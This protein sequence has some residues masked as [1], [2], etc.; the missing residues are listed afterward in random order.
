MK[1][2]PA[3]IFILTV[4]FVAPAWAEI[5]I[6]AVGPITGQDAALG[7]QMEKGARAAVE[8]INEKGGV[9]GQKLNLV[10][11]DDACDPKQAVAIANQLSS[12][13]IVAVIGGMCSGSAIPAS[14]VYNEEGILFVSPSATNPALTEQK[15]DNVFRVCGRD[16]QQGGVVAD[17][18]AKNYATA[19]IAIIHDKTAYGQGIAD[20]V[21]K[22]LTRY[23]IKEKLYDS[24][25]KG[26]RDYSSLVSLLKQQG[27]D[28]VFYGGYHTEAGLIVRQMREQKMKTI[29]VGGEGMAVGEFW[30]ITGPAGEGTL[31]SFNPDPRKKPEAAEVVKKLRGTGYDPEGYTLYTYAAVEV[32]AEAMRRANSTELSKTAAAMHGATYPTVMGSLSFNKQGDIT[33]PDY[34]MYRWTKG[35]YVP[36]EGAQ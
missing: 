17:Y 14:K 21:R 30:S 27:I 23:G 25:T 36:I 2:L 34:I 3:L 10:V 8:A 29:L 13:K 33:K 9:L 19:A 18:I 5:N 11:K 15:M 20:E 24:I 4:L 31:M 16:D 35:T 7:E 1:E 28:M 22:S 6:A 32:V 12:E 26:E